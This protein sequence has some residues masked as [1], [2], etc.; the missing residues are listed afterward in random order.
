MNKFAK[1]FVPLHRIDKWE[2][3]HYVTD[4]VHNS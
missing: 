1:L 4:R 2:E 3:I